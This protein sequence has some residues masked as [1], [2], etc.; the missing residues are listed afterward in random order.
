M[1]NCVID[2]LAKAERTAQAKNKD[3]TKAMNLRT[4]L[5][6]SRA[7]GDQNRTFMLLYDNKDDIQKALDGREDKEGCCIM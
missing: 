6:N 2:A 4:V 5:M 1:I 7:T 3:H